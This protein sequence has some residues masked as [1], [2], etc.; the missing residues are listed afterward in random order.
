MDDRAG[1]EKESSE[2][3]RS[4]NVS[5]SFIPYF[6]HRNALAVDL[7]PTML[8]LLYVHVL[9]PLSSTDVML[10]FRGRLA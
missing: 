1:R 2:K 8:F 10:D 9:F 5:H 7:F 3:E 4:N 6:V